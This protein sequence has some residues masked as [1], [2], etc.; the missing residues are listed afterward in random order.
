VVAFYLAGEG[1]GIQGV[2]NAA[3]NTYGKSAP[4]EV[5]E[6]YV[7]GWVTALLRLKWRCVSEAGRISRSEKEESS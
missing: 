3:I 5:M 6:Q 2:L 4:I 1:C 7:I